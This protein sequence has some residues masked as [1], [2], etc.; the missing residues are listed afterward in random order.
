VREPARRYVLGRDPFELE[1]LAWNAQWA[2]YGRAGEVAQ[3]ALAAFDVACWDL[4]GQ[5]LGAPYR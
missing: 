1:R 4:V 3:S 5:A 2:E